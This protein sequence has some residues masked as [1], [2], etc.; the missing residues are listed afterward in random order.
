MMCRADLVGL[1]DQQAELGGLVHHRREH[2]HAVAEA[3]L[4]MRDRAIVVGHH[5]VLLKTKVGAQPFD[6]G[7]RVAVTQAGDDG[8]F[9]GLGKTGHRCLH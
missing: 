3:E 7:R 8:G 2:D 1:L 6:G 5:Q 4:R 9:C